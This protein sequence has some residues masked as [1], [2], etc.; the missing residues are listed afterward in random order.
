MSARARA[1]DFRVTSAPDASSA[2]LR[3]VLALGLA[4]VS[5][6]QAQLAPQIPPQLTEP[7]PPPPAPVEKFDDGGLSTLQVVLIFG[8]AALVLGGVGYVIVRDAR[9]RAPVAERSRADG[10]SSQGTT[11]AVAGEPTSAARAR[12][13]ERAKRAKSKAKSV[14]QQRKRNRPR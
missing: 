8:S 4:P 3:T 5:V 9:R 12:E 14:R 11:K 7:Q 13:R 10:K 2:S 6:A 1:T